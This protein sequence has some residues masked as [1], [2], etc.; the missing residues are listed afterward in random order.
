MNWRRSLLV[1]LVSVMELSWLYPWLAIL[2]RFTT[3]QEGVLK[4]AATFGL[5]FLALGVAELLNRWHIVDRYQRIVVGVLVLLTALLMVRAQVYPGAPLFSLRWVGSSLAKLVLFDRAI[6]SELFLVLVTFAVWWRGLRLSQAWLITDTVGFRFRLGILLLIGL[7]IVQALSYRQDMTGWILS[8]FL[9]GL[10]SVALARV[11][12]SVPVGQG[13]RQFS[14]RWLLLLL[15]G[16]GGT[17]FIGLLASV[18]LSTENLA[19]LW[20]WLRP[21]ATVL[22]TIVFYILFVLSCVLAWG[23]NAI[24]QL[25]WRG[26][27]SQGLETVYLSP[28]QLPAEWLQA[29]ETVSPAWGDA[30]RQ[31]LTALVVVGLFV[32]LLTVVRRWRLRP[33]GGADV[34]RESVWSSREAG[35]GLLGGLRDGL[36]QLVG[37]WSD[38]EARR[39][40]SAATIRRIYASLLALA[41]QRGI[42]RP[43]AQTPLE[44]LPALQGTFPG[45][46]AELRALTRAYVDAH[47]G[48][49]PDTEAE[50]RALRDAWQRI[51][52]W[53][54]TRLED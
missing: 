24:L 39:D 2:G 11:K 8:L 26:E 51:H 21:V 7:L 40:Y 45:W 23:V 14:L 38:R 27:E 15:V 19:T 46:G 49:L 16:A 10:V 42:P 37:L 28:M 17:L 41:E 36:R 25:L 13:D 50:L 52:T 12:D 48:Q 47:Y 32:L 5:F 3:L 4:P 6:S 35:R 53:A 54:E 18:L 9:C 34:W 29:D 20:Q 33:S 30:V 22:G 1:I 31:G 43:P 44:Y